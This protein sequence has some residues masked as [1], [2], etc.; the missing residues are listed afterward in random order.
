MLQAVAQD[1]TGQVIDGLPVIIAALLL[2]AAL[3]LGW[4]TWL[5]RRESGREKPP[6]TKPA[7]RQSPDPAPVAPARAMPLKIRF[8]DAPD[9]KPATGQAHAVRLAGFADMVTAA[10]LAAQG[11]KQLPAR[12]DGHGGIGGLFLREVRSGGGHEALAVA[13]LCNA[14]PHDPAT[15]TDAALGAAIGELYARGAFSREVA[16]EL[17]RGLREGP[18]FFR[19]EL[20]RHDLSSGLTTISELGRRGEKLRSVARSNARLMSALWHALATLERDEAPGH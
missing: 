11:W 20:W 3:L 7:P 14:T 6:T 17:L 13:S 16:D 1:V 4:R 8:S 18:S 2:V 5:K 19:R 9:L 15:L 10:V 12:F